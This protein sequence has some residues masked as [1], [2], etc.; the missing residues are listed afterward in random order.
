MNEEFLQALIKVKSTPR[1]SVVVT[2]V[3]VRG[4]APQEIGARIIVG[5]EGLL[6][7]TIGG[8]KVEQKSI[9]YARELLSLE[10]SHDF[11][12]WNLQKD[13]GMTCGGVVSLFF[14][15]MRP[16]PIWKIAVFGAGHV[17]QELVRL[18]I[19][20]DCDI[21]CI[22]PRAEWLNK[23]PEHPRLQ[24]ISSE[25]MEDVLVELHPE[26]FITSMT[27]G[28]AFDLPILAEAMS[29]HTFPYIGVIGSESKARVLKN[30]LLKMGI[31]S[32]LIAKLNCPIGE[33]IGNN[34][35]VEIAISIVAQLMKCRD[36]YQENTLRS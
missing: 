35:P 34:Q 16:R 28:H 7:G 18:L 4:S 15:K 9:E 31:G 25:K 3:D 20:L 6:F 22:D 21:I 30:D 19:K 26:T 27:M 12:E 36:I 10:K 33:S 1:E 32:E 17:A 11:V 14:E 29:K 13:V 23:L 5:S 24:K 2:M 8:G